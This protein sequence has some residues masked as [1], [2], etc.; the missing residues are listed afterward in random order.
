MISKAL[1][2]TNME[3]IKVGF[4]NMGH[5]IRVFKGN[6]K[7]YVGKY[8]EFL[9]KKLQ[10]PSFFPELKVTLFMS[11]ADVALGSR[12]AVLANLSTILQMYKYAYEAVITYLYSV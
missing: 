2:A 10:D 11:L 9:L 4:E 12:D 5:F 8:I 3:I 1:E 7:N 6:N